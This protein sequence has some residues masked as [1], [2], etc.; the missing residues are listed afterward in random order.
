MLRRWR[1]A[2]CVASPGSAW[3]FRSRPE[4]SVSWAAHEASARF[5]LPTGR[6]VRV[7][8]PQLVDGPGAPSVPPRT[9]RAPGNPRRHGTVYQ[10]Y[11]WYLVLS[12]AAGMGR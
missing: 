1:R 5:G 10:Q 3:R 6:R 11:S 4:A 12:S 8:L 9:E 2:P 7:S